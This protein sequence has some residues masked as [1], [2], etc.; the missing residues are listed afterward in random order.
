MRSVSC[1]HPAMRWHTGW[2]REVRGDG[3]GH[4]AAWVSCPSPAIPAAGR[5]LLASDENAVLSTPLFASQVLEDGFLAAPPVPPIWMPGTPLSLRGPLGRGFSI[6]EGV[7]RLALAALGDT[8]ARLLP[9]VNLAIRRDISVAV[10]T[11]TPL[12]PLPAVVEINLLG[13]LPDA[14]SWADCLVVDLPVD[15]LPRLGAALG[16]SPTSRLPCPGQALVIVPMPCGGMADCGVC[17]LP[18]RKGWR[19]ACK[20]GPVLDLGE[21]LDA[22]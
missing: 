21:L 17:A 8:A 10:F 6:P 7:R 5:Y 12:S 13:A 11:E 20:D 16:L 19:L 1:Y 18:A 9:L 15:A 2:V 4:N 3:S 22:G 14:L